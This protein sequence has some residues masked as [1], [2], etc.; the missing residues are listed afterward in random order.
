MDIHKKCFIVFFLVT[1]I[2][3]VKIYISEFVECIHTIL[4][5]IHLINWGYRMHFLD[6]KN[7][8]S[9]L[10]VNGSALRHNKNVDGGIMA[11]HGVSFESSRSIEERKESKRQARQE[12]LEKVGTVRCG[13]N[14]SIG[15]CRFVSFALEKA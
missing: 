4:L 3:F 1:K 13:Y 2:I 11:A 7:R 9:T 15:K 10:D 5:C 14:N 8:K 12:A 6:Y